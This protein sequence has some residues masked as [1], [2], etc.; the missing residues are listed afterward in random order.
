MNTHNNSPLVTDKVAEKLRSYSA[1]AET[2]GKLTAEQLAIVY[3]H[4]WFKLFVPK[5]LGGLALSVP[6][7]V[8]LEE[9]LARIDGSL[10]WT[11]TLCAGANLF[12][13]YIDPAIAMEVFIDPMVCLGGSGQ[14]SGT[15]AVK[16]GGYEV[17]GRWRYATG[18]P[19]NTHFTANCVIEQDGKP[20]LNDDGEPLVKSF[21]FDATDVRMVA[22]WNTIGL[23]A[24]ASHSFEVDK[25]WVDQNR[26]FVIVPERASSDLPLYQ[27]PF[28]PFAQ[29]T[30]AANTLGMARHFIECCMDIAV[31][32]PQH[33][34]A[35]KTLTEL[36]D[37]GSQRIN[38]ARRV[39][40]EALDASWDALIREGKIPE[41][42]LRAIAET[43]HALVSIS[44]ETVVSLYPHCGIAAADASSAINRVWRDIFTASQHSLFRG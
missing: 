19:H 34:K 28:L 35:S 44:Q 10:G 9:E 26:S 5:D 42:A 33:G 38:H 16:N 20:V 1:A 30:L 41:M 11:V 27:Y 43:S 31:S 36:L 13:G 12:V 15:A 4:R 23:R 6:E 18:A 39:F 17:T 7:G 21:F 29:T 8:R 32:K 14:P 40:Y 22:D 25:L 3:E 2:A 24:T 37:A